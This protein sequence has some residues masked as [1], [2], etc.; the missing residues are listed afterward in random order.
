MVAGRRAAH[1]HDP[2]VHAPGQVGLSSRWWYLPG[3]YQPVVDRCRCCQGKEEAGAKLA[4]RMAEAATGPQISSTGEL[5]RIPCE[6]STGEE[7]KIC[8]R[9]PKYYQGQY[10]FT[11]EGSSTVSLFSLTSHFVV[12]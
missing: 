10:S 2:V 5:Y 12:L 11:A 3:M 1:P 9:W 4:R 7:A 8:V 6:L